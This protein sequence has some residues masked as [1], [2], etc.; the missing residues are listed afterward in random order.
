MIGSKLL[1]YATLRNCNSHILMYFIYINSC[2]EFSF[3][4]TEDFYSLE[5]FKISS[6]LRRFWKSDIFRGY[7]SSIS[8]NIDMFFM[9]IYHH[10]NLLLFHISVKLEYC[11][12][13][14]KIRYRNFRHF[15]KWFQKQ[16]RFLN[17]IIWPLNPYENCTHF[18]SLRWKKSLVLLHTIFEL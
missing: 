9:K 6:D 5:I 10:Q 12:N 13:F 15:L 2:S 18:F 16:Y 7:W 3:P 1:K 14:W 17:L 8:L 11:E 4:P